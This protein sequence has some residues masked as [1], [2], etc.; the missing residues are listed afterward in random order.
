MNTNVQQNAQ[1]GSTTGDF[2]RD[3]KQSTLMEQLFTAPVHELG[4]ILTR[5]S[6]QQTLNDSCNA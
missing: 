3:F 4:A 5:Y 2:A 1:N 6:W